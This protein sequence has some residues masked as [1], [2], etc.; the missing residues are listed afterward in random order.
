MIENKKEELPIKGDEHYSS[1][2]GHFLRGEYW[3]VQKF[4]E[5]RMPHLYTRTAV[6]QSIETGWLIKGDM[7]RYPKDGRR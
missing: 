5:T 3:K 7:P 2:G 1:K 4:L 6:P